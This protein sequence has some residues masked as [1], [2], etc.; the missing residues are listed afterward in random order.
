MTPPKSPSCSHHFA[1]ARHMSPILVPSTVQPTDIIHHTISYTDRAQYCV[2]ASQT[3]PQQVPTQTHTKHKQQPVVPSCSSR[4]PQTP[5]LPQTQHTIY[6]PLVQRYLHCCTLSST[7]AIVT[8]AAIVSQFSHP[9][10]TRCIA[11]TGSARIAL[12]ST[13]YVQESMR[14]LCRHPH[15]IRHCEHAK[16]KLGQHVVQPTHISRCG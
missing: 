6:I 8:L 10:V 5:V 11:H 12:L 15:P 7:A 9:S 3:R 13:V 2:V 14:C 4:G 16:F 1:S